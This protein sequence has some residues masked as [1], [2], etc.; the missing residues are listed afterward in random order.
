MRQLV[1][2][3][4]QEGARVENDRFDALGS[5]PS[6]KRNRVAFSDADIEIMFRMRGLE[7][8]QTE[9]ARDGRIDCSQFH[10]I[11][12]DLFDQIFHDD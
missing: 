7:G 12:I 10:F 11:L 1:I 9:H 2:G 6:R 5:K 4:L 3:S 8:F